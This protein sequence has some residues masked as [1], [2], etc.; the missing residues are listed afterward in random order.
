MVLGRVA[1]RGRA[2]AAAALCC[3]PGRLSSWD[4]YHARPGGGST[5]HRHRAQR[6]AWEGRR[7]FGKDHAEEGSQTG[8]GGTRHPEDSLP[9]GGTREAPYPSPPEL[10]PPTNCCMSGCPNCV[11]VD[12]AEALLQHYQDGGERALAAL[13]EHVEDENLKAFLRMEIQLRLRSKG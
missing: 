11:W 1:A 5:L 4:W 8:A 12:Y 9:G 7:G 6:T 13:Q 10:Q 3:G 2:V